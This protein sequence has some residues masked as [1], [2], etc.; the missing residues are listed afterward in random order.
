M[1]LRRSGLDAMRSKMV[2]EYYN[3]GRAQFFRIMF[4]VGEAKAP[5]PANIGLL[6]SVGILF[7]PLGMP[8]VVQ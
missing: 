8:H 4:F 7:Q 3:L 2:E 5:N 6:C 1:V